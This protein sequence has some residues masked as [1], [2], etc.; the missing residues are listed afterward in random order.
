MNCDI[1]NTSKGTPI[2]DVKIRNRESIKEFR[3]TKSDSLIKYLSKKK[4]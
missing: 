2:I 3:N 1:K 4:Y